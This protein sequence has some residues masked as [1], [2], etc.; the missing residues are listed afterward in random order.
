MDYAEHGDLRTYLRSKGR[1]DSKDKTNRLDFLYD[2]ISNETKL[3]YAIQVAS[4]MEYLASKK[5]SI[6][7]KNY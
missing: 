1:P 4:G 7:K 3:R 5:V 2:L 6:K